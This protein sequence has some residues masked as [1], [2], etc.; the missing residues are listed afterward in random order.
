VEICS[1]LTHLHIPD[2]AI[3]GDSLKHLEKT[4]FLQSL[5]IT[6]CKQIEKKKIPAELAFLLKKKMK[7]NRKPNP[8]GTNKL[9]SLS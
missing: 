7:A 8:K 1:N 6:C 3:A 5:D 2:T 9:E 4:P